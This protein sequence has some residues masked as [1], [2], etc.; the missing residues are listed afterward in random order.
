MNILLKVYLAA[1]LAFILS[2][3]IITLALW[4]DATL[5]GIYNGQ[6]AVAVST[7]SLGENDIE[8]ALF[9]LFLPAVTWLFTRGLRR[10]LKS[11]APF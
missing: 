7:N 10:V 8:L 9:F 11:E 6:Y 2:V 5:N 3:Y 1:G 4:F